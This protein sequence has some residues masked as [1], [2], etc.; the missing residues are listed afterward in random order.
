[1]AAINNTRRSLSFVDLTM[2][3]SGR[4]PRCGYVLRYDGISLRC[5]FCGYPRIRPGI[6]DTVLDFERS[7][8]SKVRGFLDR[9]QGSS[10][11]RLVTYHPVAL[12]QVKSCIVCG[13][14][15]VPGTPLCPLCGAV[16]S[17][18]Q[19]ITATRVTAGADQDRKVLDYIK[20]HNGTISLSQAVQELSMPLDAL[21]LSIDRL[22]AAGLLGPA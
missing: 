9:A 5:D 1:M 20:Q 10:W 16:Q 15:L 11:D 19:A 12:R 17:G 6:W 21:K 8:K 4:C 3:S 22:K 18:N 2:R 14:N 7:L 13:I